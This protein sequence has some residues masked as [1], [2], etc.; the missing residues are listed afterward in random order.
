VL[1]LSQLIMEM[2]KL[3]FPPARLTVGVAAGS[4]CLRPC[5]EGLNL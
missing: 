5:A 2:E 3:A 4:V 1:E